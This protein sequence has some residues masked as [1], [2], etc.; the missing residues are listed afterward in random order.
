M[1]C[2][3]TVSS[4]NV[5]LYENWV[6]TSSKD[7]FGITRELDP[8]LIKFDLVKLFPILEILYAGSER[9][10]RHTMKAKE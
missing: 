10:Q 1:D 6:Y 8:K 4:F 9:I 7:E 3:E 2:L 5:G